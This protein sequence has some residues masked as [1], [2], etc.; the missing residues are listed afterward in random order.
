MTQK[1]G[2]T[3][4]T[5]VG[6]LF[7]G[8]A[9]CSWGDKN[10][11]ALPFSATENMESAAKQLF[12]K[13][14]AGRW[15]AD[16]G[17]WEIRIEPDGGISSVVQPI[18]GEKVEAE[19]INTYPLVKGGQGVIKPGKWVA[20]Y[21]SVNRIL[22]VQIVLD[23][24]HMQVEDQIIEGSSFDTFTGKVAE[25]GN[26]WEAIWESFPEYIVSTDKY[27]KEKLPI[28]EEEYSQGIVIFTKQQD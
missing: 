16:R 12:P 13:D 3:A 21:N 7:L 6:V 26:T 9:G 24:F 20:D 5:L 8:L 4:G 18:G 25:S 11:C 1:A 23:S 17:H 28:N 2:I 10:K 14:L 15:V 22:T 27:K 19:R